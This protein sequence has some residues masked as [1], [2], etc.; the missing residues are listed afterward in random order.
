ML[1]LSLF[2]KLRDFRELKAYLH[3]PESE[4]EQC[5]TS[6]REARLV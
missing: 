6:A 4:A 3:P 1:N 2:L 5:S